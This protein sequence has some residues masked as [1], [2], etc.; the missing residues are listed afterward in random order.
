MYFSLRCF[1]HLLTIVAILKFRSSWSLFTN[2]GFLLFLTGTS[3]LVGLSS[4]LWRF[5]FGSW[6]ED[7]WFV[8]CFGSLFALKSTI[9]LDCFHFVLISLSLFWLFLGILF[10]WFFVIS[11]LFLG[12]FPVLFN[13]SIFSIFI[14][15]H[16]FLLF[17]IW[18]L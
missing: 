10:G 7:S 18:A 1:L 14:I 8:S 5:S 17:F 12:G 6:S 3:F 16:R 9:S 11:I 13:D 2:F 15:R 4:W